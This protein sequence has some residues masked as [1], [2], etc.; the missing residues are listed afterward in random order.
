MK[1]IGSDYQ[2]LVEETPSHN[3]LVP[4]KVDFKL[5]TDICEKMSNNSR[6]TLPWISLV[7]TLTI[8]GSS[9]EVLALQR[10]DNNSQVKNVQSCLKRLGYFNGPVNGNFGPMTENSVKRFQQA[11]RISAIGKVGP[12]TQAALQRRCGSGGRTVSAN[13]CQRGLR[14]GCDGTAVRELQQNLRTLGVY[15]GPVTGRFRQLTRN[16]VVNFQRRNGINPIGVAGPQT[17]R[18]IRLALN[19]QPVNPPSNKTPIGRSCDYRTEII[20]FGCQGDWVRQLQQRLKALNYF[21]GNPTGYFGEVTTNAVLRFQQDNRLP[22][23]GTVDAI[24]WG[25]IVNSSPTVTTPILPDSIITVGSRGSQVITLQQ[26]LKQL[27]YFYGNP[28]GVYDRSTQDAVVRFQQS[29]GLPTTGNVDGRTSQTILQV[30]RSRGGGMGGSSDFEPIYPGENSPKVEKLQKRLLELGLLK[31][32]PTGYFGPLTREGLLAFQRYQGLSETGF[33]DEQTWQKLGFNSSR[34][35]RYVIVVPLRS[36]DIYNRVLQ[37]IPSAQVGKSR[38]GDF[39][40]AG[41]YNERDVAQRQSQF[42]RDRGLDA[43]VEYF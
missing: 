35:K 28:D 30:L 37:Y 1:K 26:N 22:T 12:R 25:R 19:S 27:G 11:S 31:A 20:G 16:A 36:P 42:L 6:L 32:N 15:N 17:Q 13:D 24:T 23:T 4:V 14:S 9:S 43:R 21:N 39:V 18:A 2:N 7:T 34:D 8:L 5:F 10:G 33:V 29:Y 38:L 3:Q 41:E 40:N